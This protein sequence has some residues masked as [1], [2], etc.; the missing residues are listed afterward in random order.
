[1][2]QNHSRLALV[3]LAFVLTVPMFACDSAATKQAPTID[4]ESKPKIPAADSAPMPVAP[5][6]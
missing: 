2:L 1:V 4:T 3:G 6:K 5:A